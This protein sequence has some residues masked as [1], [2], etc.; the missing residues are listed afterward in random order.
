LVLWLLPTGEVWRAISGIS[1]GLWAVVLC[2]FLAGHAVAAVK[3]WLLA[4]SGSEVTFIAALR[5]H[6]A[7]LVANLC[8]PGVA[9]GD[10]V[11]AG[12]V[13]RGSRDKA[14]VAVGSLV[15]RLLDIFGLIL[16]AGAGGVLAAE[17]SDGSAAP[18]LAVAV[19]FVLSV[20]AILLA[21]ALAPRLPSR[22]PL[23][24][25]AKKAASALAGFRRQPGKLAAC[26]GL[27][28]LVQS[29]FI[30]LTILL[31]RS[32]GIDATVA[33]WF[34]AWPLAK[35]VAVVPISIAGLGVREATLATLLLPFGAS[36]GGVVAVGLLWQSILF[37]GGLLGGLALLVSRKSKGAGEAEAESGGEAPSNN[38]NG[39]QPDESSA[40][41]L[42][43]QNQ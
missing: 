29:G 27:S 21:T 17:F 11:R 33:A 13:I 7:G 25:L 18:L 16:L 31:A 37:S 42:A 8:L 10:I 5:A 15:D 28:M 6:F 24:N 19:L 1:L 30:G 9:G 34:F 36:A 38:S 3:W 26:L 14:R 39:G 22:I 20:A 40:H 23:S 32:S 35:L 2:A 41:R 4:V 43:G 12:M